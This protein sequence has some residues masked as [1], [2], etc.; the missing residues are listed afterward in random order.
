MATPR[1]VRRLTEDL[2]LGASPQDVRRRIEA[3]ERAMERAVT[4]P[5]LG[6]KVGLDALVG[7]IPVAGDLLG[8]GIGLYLVW[9]ARL[10]G[11][12]KWKLYRM[13][14]NVG[15]DTAVGA[16]PVAGD[17][18]DFVFRSNSANLKIVLRHLDK[19]HPQTRIID[20]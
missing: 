3:V 19:H 6:K 8:A 11:L 5:G 2:P 16:V 9:E 12:P 15:I 20:A 1:G 7:L 13:L 10:L 18:F 17:L 14:A 4:I